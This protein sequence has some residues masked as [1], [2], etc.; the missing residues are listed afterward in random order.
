M[1]DVYIL[2][3]LES[4]V[5]TLL[6]TLP[7]LADDE[8]GPEYHVRMVESIAV[9]MVLC[10]A[11][12]HRRDKTNQ[13]QIDENRCSKPGMKEHIAT[14]R[15]MAYNILKILERFA[16]IILGGDKWCASRKRMTGRDII[17]ILMKVCFLV[18]RLEA[19]CENLEEFNRGDG[20]ECPESIMA[21]LKPLFLD[22][23]DPA[24]F[25]R[26]KNIQQLRVVAENGIATALYAPYAIPIQP[27]RYLEKSNTLS[28]KVCLSTF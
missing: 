28:N 24:T 15:W 11:F 14:Q 2:Q 16:I 5:E 13:L 22:L 10:E 4:R 27:S 23:F 25:G 3:D 26:E 20:V 19:L 9:F 8:L 21:E 17:W 7:N 1:D 6:I 12:R 18:P